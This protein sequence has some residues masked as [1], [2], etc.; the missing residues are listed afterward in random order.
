MNK[1]LFSILTFAIA[2]GLL[3]PNTVYFN[4]N[5]AEKNIK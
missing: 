5:E 4:I 2:I 1:K 3:I